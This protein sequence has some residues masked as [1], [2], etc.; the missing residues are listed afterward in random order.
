VERNVH[1]EVCPTSSLE[2]GGWL[3]Q[4]SSVVW[5][6]HPLVRMLEAECSVSINSD[7]PTVFKTSV[8]EQVGIVEEDMGV[9]MDKIKGIMRRAMEASFASEETKAAIMEKLE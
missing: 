1:F 5:K 3:G 9:K 4:E 6:D 8:E 7:D 2:T